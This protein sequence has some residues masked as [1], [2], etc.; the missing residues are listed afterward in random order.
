M[1]V[2]DCFIFFN[3]LDLLEIRMQLLGD[4]VDYFVLVEADRTF[5]NQPK[6]L[7]FAENRGRYARW[8]DKI[9]YV[10][11]EHDGTG[12]DFSR[13]SFYTPTLGPWLLERQQRDGFAAINSELAADDIVLVSDVDEIPAP[14]AVREAVARLTREPGGAP[15]YVFR[16]VM[17]HYYLNMQST[18]LDRIHLGTCAVRGEYFRSMAP[19][20]VRRS[21]WPWPRVATA[22]WHFSFLGVPAEI[23][24]KIQSYSH[25]EFNHPAVTDADRITRVLLEGRGVT[26]RFGHYYEQRPLSSYPRALAAIMAD[27]PHLLCNHP[28]PVSRYN[29]LRRGLRR[30]SRSE[31]AM[32]ATLRARIRVGHLERGLRGAIRQGRLAVGSRRRR[33]DGH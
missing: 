23:A 1:R 5:S 16:Q 3:E 20:L 14:E 18:G 9:R 29:L 24:Y 13:P 25:Q 27:Y 22:G 4:V 33:T 8:A 26:D 10:S 6:P 32:D 31:R 28:T 11:V 21:R 17:H 30:L 12:L 15:G 2:F 19:H 7:Y